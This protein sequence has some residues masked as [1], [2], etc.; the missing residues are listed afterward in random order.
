[1]QSVLSRIRTRVAVSISYDDSHLLHV[2]LHSFIIW[3]TLSSQSPYN[4]P[5]LSD[6]CRKL[7]GNKYKI[8]ID[9]WVGKVIHWELC[10][11]LKFEN[12]TKWYMHN[13]ES[14]LENEMHTVL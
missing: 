7:A 8:R 2:H 4:L 5:L 3:L 9:D 12:S 1:M 6:E 13:P 11:K 10:K 14:V